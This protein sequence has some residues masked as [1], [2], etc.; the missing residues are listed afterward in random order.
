[1]HTLPLPLIR[2]QVLI[3]RSFTHALL[4]RKWG[5]TPLPNA[6]GFIFESTA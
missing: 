3:G 5:V 1:M 4:L 2:D 6:W